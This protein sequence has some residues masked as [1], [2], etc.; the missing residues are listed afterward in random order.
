LLALW[1]LLSV[2]NTNWITQIRLIINVSQSI[3]FYALF[4]TKIASAH[5]DHTVKVTEIATGK[6][7]QVLS[8]HQ[9]TPWSIAFHPT[10]SDI[11]ASGCLGGQVRIWDLRVSLPRICCPNVYKSHFSAICLS[12]RSLRLCIEGMQIVL[13]HYQMWNSTGPGNCNIVVLCL[14]LW[15]GDLKGG[16]LKAELVSVRPCNQPAL[17]YKYTVSGA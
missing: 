7:M 6:C 9:R 15:V 2:Y 8:G 11:L 4:S 14:K 16:G 12:H 10:Y 13:Y 5:G 1:L 17:D 3:V